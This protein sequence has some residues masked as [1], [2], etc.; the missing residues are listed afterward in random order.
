MEKMTKQ[1][2]RKKTQSTGGGGQQ[3]DTNLYFGHDLFFKSALSEPKVRLE[4]LTRHVPK[5]F[6]AKIDMGSVK[7]ENNSFID[8]Q[9]KLS[10]TDVLLSAKTKNG[11]VCYFY[12]LIEHTTKPDKMLPF[13]AVCYMTKVMTE[14]LKRYNTTTLPIV[15]PILFYAGNQRYNHSIDVFDLFEENKELAKSIYSKPPQFIDLTKISNEELVKYP[16]SG[17][18]EYVLK[19]IFVENFMLYVDAM[20]P[21][22]KRLGL[23][24]L[25]DYIQSIFRYTLKKGRAPDAEAYRDKF[26]EQLTPAAR[27]IVMSMMQ[28]IEQARFQAGLMQGEQRGIQK[29]VQLGRQEGLQKTALEFLRAGSD[30]RFVSKVTG[31]PLSKLDAMLEEQL[32]KD[33]AH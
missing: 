26:A 20:G 13:R 29:G 28:E 27:E 8:K 23:E 3:Q 24:E 31:L 12:F 14:H 18:M 7:V 32:E 25:Y 5:D 21:A 16:Y 33:E 1:S 10:E 4:L 9:L 11:K 2:G 19:N 17:I 22:L 15:Y 6:L 30:P